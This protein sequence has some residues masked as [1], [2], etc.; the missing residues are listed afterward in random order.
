MA[1]VSRLAAG[2]ERATPEEIEEHQTAKLR[3][4]LRLAGTTS[5]YAGVLRECGINP[6]D[7]TIDDLARLPLLDKKLIQRQG[8]ALRIPEARA[9]IE[10]HTGGSTG[11]PIRFWQDID[12][13]V[14]MS[15]ATLMANRRAGVFPG[16]RVAKLWGAP[17][18]R[19]KIEGPLGTIRLWTLN[20]RYYDTF[21]IGEDRLEA[22][23]QSLDAF[24]PDVIQAYAS[25]AHLLA[26]FLKKNG[27][28]P[29]YP[30]VSVISSAERLYPD[31]RSTI[32]EV[33]R[34]KV[35]D[36]YGSREASAIAS[37]CGSNQGLHVFMPSY[38]VE[39][40]DPETG[41]IVA[42]GS[43]E[44]V[45][46]CLDNLAMP[47]IRYRIGDMGEW[48]DGPCPCGSS[49]RRLRRIVGRTTDSFRMVDGR[50][51]HG[52]YFT[53]LFYG[54]KGVTQF[55]FIQESLNGFILR[56]VPGDGYLSTTAHRIG[57]EIRQVIGPDARLA[58]EIHEN[59]PVTASGKFR[60]TISHLDIATSAARG[61]AA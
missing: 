29:G 31:M 11:E 32:E 44:I 51:I 27:I 12:C 60:F 57:E 52:E 33:F 50:L 1:D 2:L 54:A 56:L 4:L 40:I 58:I 15:V 38:I 21:D 47:M 16:C 5:Y 61:E 41:K 37:E 3:R 23:H 6:A 45:L 59:I 30:R 9:V 36:R 19:R 26:C 55:Q 20:M 7:A 18:D 42:N 28:R 22:Y 43:G 8:V 39:L 53:H 48:E 13:R 10:N 25:S 35:F 17:Q 34:V 46:T 14:H 24:Q 49:F